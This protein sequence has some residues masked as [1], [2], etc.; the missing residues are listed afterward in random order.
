MKVIYPGSF[1]P[2]TK[3]HM[4]IIERI[5]DKFDEVVVAVLVNSE[6][7]NLF[8]LEERKQLIKQ[9][10]KDYG[11]K[12]VTIESFDGLLIEFAK[13]IGSKIIVRGLRAI[14]DYEYE[15]QI[16]HINS[17]LY[18]GLETIFLVS[19]AE[20]SYISSSVVKEVASYKGDIS[21][22]VSENVAEKIMDKL[23]GG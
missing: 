19:K 8:T 23:I 5:S 12:N 21:T 10:I 16:A 11:L 17:K 22:F 7:N 18:E 6:K 15:L 1:D 2:I 9:E 20:Y 13:K 3:G 14:S 4:D